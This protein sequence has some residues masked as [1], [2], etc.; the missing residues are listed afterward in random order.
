MPR[1]AN[2]ARVKANRSYTIDEAAQA[3]GVTTATIRNWIRKG[4]QVL[5]SQ[6]PALILG[7]HLKAF[8]T[9]MKRPKN[10]PLSVGEFYCLSCKSR[11]RPALGMVQ[12]EPLSEM[13]GRLSALCG[14]CE[15]DCSRF[16]SAAAL[17]DWAAVLDLG[18]SAPRHD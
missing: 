1:R 9:E 3:V 13:N 10:G 6:R 16:V 2:V 14:H 8:I 4:L 17:P 12:Y 18:K 5:S 7:E 11:G 15:R